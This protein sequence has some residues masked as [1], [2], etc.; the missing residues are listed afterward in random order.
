[1]ADH[2]QPGAELP[3]ACAVLDPKRADCPYPF[4]ELS[5]CGIGFKLIQAYAQKH[6]IAT[7][8]VFRFLD[9]VAVSIASDIVPIVGENRV[10]THLGLIRFNST[11]CSGLKALISFCSYKSNFKVTD[12][13][14]QIYPSINDVGRFYY[15]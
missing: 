15:A 6:G 11:P 2:H 10:L 13:L 4:K 12:L 5:G 9:L 14:F 8:K 3:D 7:E 1:I